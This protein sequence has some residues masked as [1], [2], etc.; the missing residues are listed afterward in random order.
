LPS[1]SSEPVASRSAAAPAQP[2]SGRPA[3]ALAAAAIESL[4]PYQWLKSAL[5]FVPLAAAHRLGEAALVMRA[6]HAFVAF[7]LCA[8]AVYLLNDLRDAPADRLHPHKRDRPIAAGRLPG[9]LALALA[10]VLL[11]GA[12]AAV[13]P[14]GAAPAA[15][16]AL[17]LVVMIAYTLRLKAVVLLDALVL[18]GG[19]AL[20]VLTGALAVHIPPS[21]RLLAFCIFLFFSLALVKRYAELALLRLRFGPAAHAR[22]YLLDDQEFVLALG[23]ACGA[24]SVL[25]LALYMSSS[26]V[27]RLYTRSG[28]I[29]VTCVLLLY[30]ISHMWL[31]AHRGRMTDDPLV[32]AIKSPLSLT[33][34]LLM[35]VTAWLAV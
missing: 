8:S 9:T 29:W 23:T 25:V 26:T 11:A 28:F 18:A 10:P 31:T 6:V 12:A 17:Y 1:F 19:Y 24:L 34:V 16:I 15:A 2:G 13:W 27:E 4:R 20:R 33:L 14:L 21:A 30:W 35:G 7:S 32:F 3:R 5:V 22:A